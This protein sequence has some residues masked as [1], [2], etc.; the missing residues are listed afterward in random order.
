MRTVDSPHAHPGYVRRNQLTARESAQSKHVK[1]EQC[2]HE[3]GTNVVVV[4]EL[5][6]KAGRALDAG[7]TVP[8]IVP[9]GL[10][11]QGDGPQ[12]ALDMQG[13]GYEAESRDRPV[14]RS[15]SASLEGER[16][17]GSPQA[18]GLPGNRQPARRA[19]DAPLGTFP[20]AAIRARRKSIVNRSPSKAVTRPTR[21][22]RA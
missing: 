17:D 21:S 1:T 18:S 2:A 20:C 10:R 12:L 16:E 3:T 11:K 9:V 8:A 14:G 19:L 6:A 22:L 7:V 13:I 5:H 4:F 15:G